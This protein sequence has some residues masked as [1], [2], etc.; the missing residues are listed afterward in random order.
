MPFDRRKIM[1]RDYWTCITCG[2]R[3]DQHL[4]QI[5]HK[6]KQDKTQGGRG[7]VAH[8]SDWLEKTHGL[9][10]SKTEIIANYI[11]HP[12]NVCVTCSQICNDAQNIFYSPI[13]RDA[14]L[15]RIYQ[16]NLKE[17]SSHQK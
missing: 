16:D 17:L 10:L 7:S 8:I 2:E 9:L 15:E 3:V 11:N 4:I 13:K 5:A 14:L 1:V 12:F 6:I